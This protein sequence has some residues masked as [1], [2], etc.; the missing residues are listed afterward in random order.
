M[1][2]SY[3]SFSKIPS[4]EAN[5]VHVMKMAQAYRQEGHDVELIAPG[6]KGRVPSSGDLFGQYG[7]KDPFDIHFIGFG[8][9]T[10]SA[11]IDH[12]YAM[13]A[14][15]HSRKRGAQVVH[16]RHLYSAMWASLLGLSTFFEVHYPATGGRLGDLYYR[17][18]LMG[19]GFHRLIAI[20]QALKD[21]FPRGPLAPE[22]ILV[23]PDGIDLE[24]F[25]GMP[26][27]D[28]ARTAL[29]I[30]LDAFVAG[31]VG[32][33]YSG[34]G[35]EVILACAKRNPEMHFLIVGGRD[36]DIKRV[37]EQLTR[38]SIENVT[39]TG[40]V[41]N[42]D[43]PTYMSACEALLMPYQRSVSSADSGMDTAH[44]M[45][46]MKM[47]EYMAAGRLII[48]S[49][50]PVIREVLDETNAV[51]CRPDDVDAWNAAL[52][53]ARSDAEWS[54]AIADKARKDVGR[55]TWRNRVRRILAT[56]QQPE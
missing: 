11:F 53:R 48:T 3:I 19:G 54:W 15:F 45:S 24:R 52:N 7:I 29:G 8:A 4:R 33:L 42:N 16:T 21:L 28:E 25:A 12:V 1:N 41:N 46:P 2:I 43:I 44:V 36:E 27:R 50:L 5:S 39:L 9:G 30:P 23:A 13:N 20:T 22:K 55:H 51:L 37:K 56:L 47:F 14:V 38:Q 49:D 26:T 31:Y 18:M 40:F 35:V 6:V 10:P 32:H 17:A 34:R